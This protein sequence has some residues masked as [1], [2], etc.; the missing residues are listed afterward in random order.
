MSIRSPGRSAV[1]LK[2]LAARLGVHPSTVSRVATGDPSA[3][4]TAQT[5]ERIE[6]LLRTTGYRPNGIARSLKLRQSF[7][8]GMIVP[9]VANPFFA[10]MY[11][12]I[13]DASLPRGYSVILC[14]T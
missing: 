9:D 12:G 3:R 5:R 1:T 8:L 4:V 13:E 10:A 14:N 2:E 7:V 11:R 6:A